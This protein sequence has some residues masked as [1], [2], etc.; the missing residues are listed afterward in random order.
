MVLSSVQVGAKIR[1]MELPLTLS[2]N[3][4]GE[5]LFTLNFTENLSKLTSDTKLKTDPLVFFNFSGT[6]TSTK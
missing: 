6:L 2:K 5:M 4:K 1:K 3:D